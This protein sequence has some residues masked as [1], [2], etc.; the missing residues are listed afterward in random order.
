MLSEGY[1]FLGRGRF[2]NKQTTN[3]NRVGFLFPF[4][5]PKFTPCQRLTFRHL[6]NYIIIKLVKSFLSGSF[7]KK[8]IPFPLCN[9]KTLN[10][11]N[12]DRGYITSGLPSRNHPP[13][14]IPIFFIPIVCKRENPKQALN[15][16]NKYF[17]IKK[18][19]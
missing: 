3:R 5:I 10:K 9:R 15:K 16:I 12:R 17:H 11:T 6:F 18:R 13:Y 8:K 4:Q 19:V 14:Y 1:G 7:P 2:Q